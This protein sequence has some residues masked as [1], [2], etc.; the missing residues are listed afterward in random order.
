MIIKFNFAYVLYSFLVDLKIRVWKKIEKII[1]LKQ[2]KCNW[3]KTGIKK[4]ENWFTLRSCLVG[5]VPGGGW[6]RF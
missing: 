1:F 3:I 4:T 6:K 5:C 2:T